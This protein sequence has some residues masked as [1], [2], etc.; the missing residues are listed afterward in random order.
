MIFC[1]YE[2]PDVGANHKFSCFSRRVRT[3]KKRPLTQ[4]G[5]YE[6]II[7]EQ[8]QKSIRPNVWILNNLFYRFL[9]KFAVAL[10]AESVD[11]K[12]ARRH[13]SIP[14][15]TVA[16]LAE[17]VD[18]KLSPPKRFWRQSKVALLAE[19][20]D[21]KSTHAPRERSGTQVALLAESVDRKCRGCG[22]HPVPRMSLSSRRAWIERCGYDLR[23]I[24]DLSR[25]PRGER[26]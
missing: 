13:M 2:F 3:K 15:E 16:L 10:L 6:R 5:H 12:E 26:G 21:R 17:S 8:K 19:S 24:I 14:R 25:S 18:R 9:C 7:K 23:N 11:R 1:W 22:R 4:I 20:V